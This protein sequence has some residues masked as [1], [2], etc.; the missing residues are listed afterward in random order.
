MTNI[1]LVKSLRCNMFADRETINEAYDYALKVAKNSGS[2][3]QVLTA[4]HV[5]MNTIANV[6]EQNELATVDN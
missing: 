1:E 2:S 4:L 6:I 5:M 3:P